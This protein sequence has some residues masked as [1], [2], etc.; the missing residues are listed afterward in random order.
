MPE[1]KPDHP[2]HSVF[3]LIFGFGVSSACP[4]RKEHL[5]PPAWSSDTANGT[6]GLFL[7]EVLG[8]RRIHCLYLVLRDTFCAQGWFWGAW[9]W[10]W[11]LS[12]E[13]GR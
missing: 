3:A 11:G 6:W 10:F 8:W 1:G 2:V 12:V 7:W 5:L 13:G 9:G 4:A